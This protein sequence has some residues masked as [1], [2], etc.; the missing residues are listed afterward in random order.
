MN[1]TI[2]QANAYGTD[3]TLEVGDRIVVRIKGRKETV[4]VDT[5]EHRTEVYVHPDEYGENPIDAFE[6]E[7]DPIGATPP[8]TKK[9]TKPDWIKPTSPSCEVCGRPVD[10][11][12]LDTGDGWALVWEEWCENGHETGAPYGPCE[13]LEDDAWPFIDNTASSKDWEDLGIRT[14]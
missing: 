7:Y 5:S 8:L 4:V 6:R 2:Q 13:L 14:E 1:L 12:A 9:K 3:V 10:L 11:V